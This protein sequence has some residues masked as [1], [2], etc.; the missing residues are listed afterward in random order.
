MHHAM[1]TI[2]A[3]P[4]KALRTILQPL[5]DLAQKPKAAGPGT[6]R[7]HPG[8]QDLCTWGN[9]SFQYKA[10]GWL[11]CSTENLKH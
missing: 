9:V 10:L 11:V 3:R 7:K 8:S 6:T 1:D 2:M 5:S 4:K